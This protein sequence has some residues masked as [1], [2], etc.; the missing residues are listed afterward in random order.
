M[1]GGGCLLT[2]GRPS[3]TLLPTFAHRRDHPPRCSTPPQRSAIFRAVRPTT[4][5]SCVVTRREIGG[6]SRIPADPAAAPF[7]RPRPIG[8]PR[9]SRSPN[10]C[11]ETDWRGGQMAP[12]ARCSSVKNT[13]LLR[14]LPACAMGVR[15]IADT[16]RHTRG[17]WCSTLAEPSIMP[18]RRSRPR[19]AT[20]IFPR[21]SFG[22]AALTPTYAIFSSVTA[23]CV[24]FP[25][26][27]LGACSSSWLTSMTGA[28]WR[29][30]S[31]S[32]GSGMTSPCPLAQRE[33]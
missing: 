30:H 33:A 10:G 12:A 2:G 11:R 23:P 14:V 22:S 1:V 15:E 20:R 16:W 5:W 17:R 24:P 26:P 28:L 9:R 25:C 19:Q 6:N 29:S 27:R 21:H 13:S 7:D 18:A 31:G 3:G 4:P 8:W 32:L